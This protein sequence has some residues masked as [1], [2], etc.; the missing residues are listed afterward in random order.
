MKTLN[1]I[2]VHVEA[3]LVRARKKFPDNKF[4]LLAF[5]EE[6]GEVTK[7]MLDQ[8]YKNSHHST[9]IYAEIIQAIAMGVRLIQEGDADLPFDPNN[10]LTES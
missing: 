3:E 7:A 4:L 9:E 1:Q 6:A 10:I 2:M 8:H 5:N